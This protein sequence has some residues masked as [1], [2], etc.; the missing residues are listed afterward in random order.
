M[1][2]FVPAEGIKTPWRSSH[3]AKSPIGCHKPG[4][5][6]HLLSYRPRMRPTSSH[7]RRGPPFNILNIRK[8]SY[9]CICRF[10][11]L[12]RL[13]VVCIGE[14]PASETSERT[15]NNHDFLYRCA[16]VK[17]HLVGRSVSLCPLPACPSIAFH[18][19]SGTG[20]DHGSRKT[21]AFPEHVRRRGYETSMRLVVGSSFTA[22]MHPGRMSH[23]QNTVSSRS[24]APVSLSDGL[25]T[26]CTGVVDGWDRREIRSLLGNSTLSTVLNR[27]G[28]RIDGTD[29]SPRAPPMFPSLVPGSCSDNVLFRL[30]Q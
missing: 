19:D 22:H 17:S 11:K 2:N 6:L 5:S 20:R 30:L 16:S 26:V 8:D 12:V 15:A 24:G 14:I 23:I 4:S 21:V 29:S 13:A 18:S 9:S 1:Q 3:I 28:D 25:L 7:T 10:Q 27:R